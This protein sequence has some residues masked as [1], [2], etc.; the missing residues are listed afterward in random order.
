MGGGAYRPLESDAGCT[1]LGAAG[2]GPPSAESI[3]GSKTVIELE[4][5]WFLNV[6]ILEIRG[7]RSCEA[8]GVAIGCERGRREGALHETA[9]L[10]L[11]RALY[12]VHVRHR[13]CEARLDVAQCLRG[14]GD[15]W[16]E[17][18]STHR[19]PTRRGRAHAQPSLGY[20]P[21]RREDSGARLSP[22]HADVESPATA[23]RSRR[24]RRRPRSSPTR[25]PGLRDYVYASRAVLRLPSRL[26]PFLS[27]TNRRI[28]AI[29]A[30]GPRASIANAHR[31][32]T[33][34]STGGT[35]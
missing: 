35:S 20:R 2:G 11:E 18:T 13:K 14:Q 7:Q 6:H 8:G 24:E 32:P 5:S 29:P 10:R 9:L 30:S 33:T 28:A 4:E 17:G 21:P 12:R 15:L 26:P 34:C 3:C 25:R 31:Q 22:S 23:R 19:P 16:S 1:V 27:L